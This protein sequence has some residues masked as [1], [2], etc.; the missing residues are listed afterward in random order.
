MCRARQSGFSLLEVLIATIILS[1]GLVGIATLQLTGSA[2]TE[3]SLHRSHASELARE[4]F[5]RVRANYV[6]SKAGNYDIT[7]LS[8]TTTDCNGTAA[9]CTRDQLRDHDLRAWGTRVTALLPGAD[10]SIT[11]GP[12]DDENPVEIS[13][14]MEWDQSRGQRPVVSETFTFKLMGLNI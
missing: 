8:A 4:I 3:S 12:D 6:E 13:I 7:T 11:T 1:I 14:T 5:E 9:N 2:F 10:A